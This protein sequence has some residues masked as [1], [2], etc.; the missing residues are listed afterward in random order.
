[1]ID[2][3]L[4]RLPGFNKEF[5][6]W[7]DILLIS[8]CTAYKPILPLNQQIIIGGVGV[9]CIDANHCP[10]A[11]II[12]F[13]PP[14]GRYVVLSYAFHSSKRKFKNKNSGCICFRTGY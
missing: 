9:T 5:Q 2:K 11:I 10:G 8:Y 3:K 6:S 4:S 12:L 7:K 13:E 1:M 14:M